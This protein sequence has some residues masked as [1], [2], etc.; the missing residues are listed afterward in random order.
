VPLGQGYKAIP[1]NWTTTGA[2]PGTWQNLTN[3]PFGL[4]GIAKPQ[5]FG[6]K[7]VSI[8][9]AETLREREYCGFGGG[10][11][12]SLWGNLLVVGEFALGK[13][14]AGDAG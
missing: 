2:E 10:V 4:S 14:V 5:I 6:W 12:V 8:L 1:D 9:L 11:G 13:V 3:G 7:L